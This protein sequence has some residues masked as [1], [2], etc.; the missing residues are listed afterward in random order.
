MSIFEI[1]ELEK[2]NSNTILHKINNIDRLTKDQKQAGK[3]GEMK[4]ITLH[5]TNQTK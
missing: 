2:E 4:R 5:N 1:L 3:R